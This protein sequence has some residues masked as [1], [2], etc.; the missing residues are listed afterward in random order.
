MSQLISEL[1]T[2]LKN[3]KANKLAKATNKQNSMSL[4]MMKII[5]PI[6]MVLFVL[7]SSASFGIYILASNIA[8]IAVGE[9]ISLIVNKLTKKKQEEVE[10]CLEKEADRLIKKGKFQE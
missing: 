9:I 6:V 8:S 3:K 10:A 2:K 5:M 1:H 4:K 7:T